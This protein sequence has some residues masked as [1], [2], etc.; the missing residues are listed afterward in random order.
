MAVGH[1]P[2][3]AVDSKKEVSF[4]LILV[5]GQ[6]KLGDGEKKVPFHEEIKSSSLQ[7]MGV[8]KL[9]FQRI[10]S[11]SLLIVEINEEPAKIELLKKLK[12]RAT[13]KPQGSELSIF[14]DQCSDYSQKSQSGRLVEDIEHT[15]MFY[16]HFKNSLVRGQFDHKR[17][18]TLFSLLTF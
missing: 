8:S 15:F 5:C 9:E 10:F 1:Q 17:L 18:F 13:S 2:A 7:K 12:E 11:F 4:H 6:N 16:L 3:L 14:I